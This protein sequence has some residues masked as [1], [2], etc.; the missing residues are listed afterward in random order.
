MESFLDEFWG[1]DDF[2]GDFFSS[3]G[4]EGAGAGLFVAGE[5]GFDVGVGGG[6]WGVFLDV[7][8]DGLGG[9]GDHVLAGGVC[10]LKVEV[11][12]NGVAFDGGSNVDQLTMVGGGGGG[13]FEVVDVGHGPED[14]FAGVGHV[15]EFESGGAVDVFDEK[16]GGTASGFGDE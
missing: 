6:D 10:G 9:D 16:H 15:V 1:E 5:V 4:S 11:E 12:V 13:A 3:A 2:G 8:A 14:K 7:V